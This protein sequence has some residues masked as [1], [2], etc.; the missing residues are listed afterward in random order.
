[1]NGFVKKVRNIR[2]ENLLYTISGNKFKFVII[3]GLGLDY[4]AGIVEPCL[5]VLSYFAYN[6]RK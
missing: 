4:E 2:I 3:N 6:F 1:M 5:I